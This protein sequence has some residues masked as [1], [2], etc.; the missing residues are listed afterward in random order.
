MGEACEFVVLITLQVAPVTLLAEVGF[1]LPCTP[2]QSQGDNRGGE[3][4]GVG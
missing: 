3:S 4:V 1:I 2:S